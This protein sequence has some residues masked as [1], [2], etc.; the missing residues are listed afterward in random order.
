MQRLVRNHDHSRSRAVLDLRDL[1]QI[2][3]CGLLSTGH[4]SRNARSNLS[5]S[6]TPE[7]Q[8]ELLAWENLMIVDGLRATIFCPSRLR[9]SSAPAG[10]RERRFRHRALQVLA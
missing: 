9:R 8:S 7:L 2:R 6:R 1:H 5:P 4:D 3:E 10:L